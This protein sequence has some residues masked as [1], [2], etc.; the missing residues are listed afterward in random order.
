MYNGTKLILREA[1]PVYA[2]DDPGVGEEAVWLL[3]RPDILKP[4]QS[5]LA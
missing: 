1:P 2:D 5:R 4:V 3:E